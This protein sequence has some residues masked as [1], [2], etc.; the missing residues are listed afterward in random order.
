LPAFKAASLLDKTFP[1][2]EILIFSEIAHYA[3]CGMSG[4][5]VERLKYNH[6]LHVPVHSL[7]VELQYC[8]QVLPYLSEALLAQLGAGERSRRCTYTKTKC[9]PLETTFTDMQA[10]LPR[11]ALTTPPELHAISKG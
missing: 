7:P 9:N 8:A 2:G 11:E 1:V 4:Y 3:S 6:D 5:Q 10:P